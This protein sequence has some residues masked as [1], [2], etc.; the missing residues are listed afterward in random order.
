MIILERLQLVKVMI[1][2]QNWIEMN[3]ESGCLLDHP[4]FKKYR[5]LITIDFS[6]RQKLD[7]DPKSIQEIN[8]TEDLD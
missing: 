7:A 6:K 5:R 4:F 1:P 8:F 2:Q 3:D